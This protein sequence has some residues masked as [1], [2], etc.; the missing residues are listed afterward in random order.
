M[1][2]LRIA[3]AHLYKMAWQRI[4]LLIAMIDVIRKVA[5]VTSQRAG[6]LVKRFKQ[7]QDFRELIFG[8]LFVVS[9]VAQP[10]FLG[11]KLDENLRSEERRVGKEC[12]SRWSP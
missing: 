4:A 10:H 5:A 2:R 6:V 3:L 11:A 8:K 9:Q 12:R 7:L 1:H